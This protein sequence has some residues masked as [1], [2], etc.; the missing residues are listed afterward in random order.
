MILYAYSAFTYVVGV[1][2]SDGDQSL[3]FGFGTAL[4]FLLTWLLI[5]YIV[6]VEVDAWVYVANLSR[7]W[8]LPDHPPALLNIHTLNNGNKIYIFY[9]EFS[10][11]SEEF[12]VIS[13]FNTDRFGTPSKRR[14]LIENA[15]HEHE[16]TKSSVSAGTGDR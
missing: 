3:I 10:G 2:T 7:H 11:S 16:R 1:F 15:L 12:C 13:S 8:R 6:A 14:R 4:P 9:F 5:L